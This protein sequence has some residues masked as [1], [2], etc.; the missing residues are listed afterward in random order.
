MIWFQQQVVIPDN[1]AEDLRQ[2]LNLPKAADTLAIVM[3]V[4]GVLIFI[5]LCSLFINRK[6]RTLVA[7]Q[8]RHE[9]RF[10]KETAPLN[11]EN[12]NSKNRI[13]VKEM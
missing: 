10:T 6:M 2:L 9:T 13:I 11:G 12:S 4:L 7:D 5:Y 1:M 3:I 8:K